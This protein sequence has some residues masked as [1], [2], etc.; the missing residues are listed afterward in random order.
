MHEYTKEPAGFSGLWL[1]ISPEGDC[2]CMVRSEF[3]ADAVLS[4]LNRE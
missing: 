1:I 3:E 2:I 4:H